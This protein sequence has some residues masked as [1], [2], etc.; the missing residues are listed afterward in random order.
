MK[1]CQLKHRLEGLFGKPFSFDS[2]QG[3]K[4][5]MPSTQSFQL[6]ERILKANPRQEQGFIVKKVHH[7]LFILP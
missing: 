1:C 2:D 7:N 3:I 5:L 6:W 4:I